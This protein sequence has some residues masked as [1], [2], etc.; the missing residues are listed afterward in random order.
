MRRVY[1]KVRIYNPSDLSHSEEVELLV[2]SG[3]PY[4]VVARSILEKIRV[5]PI[6]TIDI[7]AFGGIIVKREHGVAIVEYEGKSRGTSVIFGEEEDTPI[8]GVPLLEMLGYEIDSISK[9]II[10]IRGK[11][12]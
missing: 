7:K 6:G 8:M 11:E 2:D 1:V 3:S 5:K 4:P 10:P 9:K 12:I